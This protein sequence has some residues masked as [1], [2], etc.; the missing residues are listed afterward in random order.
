[1]TKINT[2]TKLVV[3]LPGKDKK[4]QLSFVNDIERNDAYRELRCAGYIVDHEPCERFTITRSATE[5][6]D[7]V[8]SFLG[9]AL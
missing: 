6:M 5:A 1:M 4:I 9:L 2:L 3:N 8:K 7:T